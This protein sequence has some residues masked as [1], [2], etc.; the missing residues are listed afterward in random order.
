MHALDEGGAAYP[1]ESTE[2]GGE[3]M[4]KIEMKLTLEE[5]STLNE[6]LR[7]ANPFPAGRR[8]RVFDKVR[9]DIRMELALAVEEEEA[10]GR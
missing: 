7:F 5:L 2:D 9:S 1:Q 3:N 10:N 8:K 6:A 4:A